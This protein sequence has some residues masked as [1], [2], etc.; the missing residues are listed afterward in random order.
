MD[1]QRDR[2]VDI[3]RAHTA[4]VEL[5]GVIAGAIFVIRSQDFISRLQIE[6]AGNNV[7]AVRCIRDVDQVI[8]VGVEVFAEYNP[9]LAQQGWQLSPEEQD[10]LALQ[11]SLPGLVGFKYRPGRCSI[12]AMVEKDNCGI[13]EEM[14]FQRGH[15][16]ILTVREI[17][18]SRCP[19][20][21][22]GSFSSCKLQAGAD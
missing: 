2:P 1:G 11:P 5:P 7:D 4:A 13:Q 22:M 15:A 14:F 6:G 3:A 16:P 21:P 8:G 12:R 9:R 18:S 19:P 20:Q 17:Q 10:G